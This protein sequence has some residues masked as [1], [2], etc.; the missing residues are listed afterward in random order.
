MD[1]LQDS[2]ETSK[3]STKSMVSYVLSMQ[4]K[5]AKMTEA[6]QENKT[7]AQQ[8]QKHWYNKHLRNREFQTG[9]Q[10]LVLSCY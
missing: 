6:V 7:K 8:Q 3:T 2:W 9:D 10:V 5:L 4:E 1:A